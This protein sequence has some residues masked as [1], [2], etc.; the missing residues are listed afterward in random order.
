MHRVFFCEKFSQ[1]HLIVWQI[2][3]L[4]FVWR[5]ITYTIP[6]AWKEMFLECGNNIS[7][8]I[9]NERHLIKNHQIYCLQKINNMQLILKVE[10]PTAQTSFEENFRNPELK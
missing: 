6:H 5:Q 8:L 3:V 2:S 4:K 10:K 7:N 1:V 9:I